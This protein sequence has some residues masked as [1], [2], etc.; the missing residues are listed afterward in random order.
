MKKNGFSKKKLAVFTLIFALIGGL[1]I[2]NSL[3]APN[4]NLLGD[5]DGDNT[6]NIQDLSILLSNYGTTNSTADINSDGT[7]NVLDLSTLLSHYGESYSGGQGNYCPNLSLGQCVPYDAASLWNTP[8]PADVTTDPMSATFI[9]AISDNNLSLTSDPDQYTI[10]VYLVDNNTPTYTVTGSGYFHSYDAGNDTSSVGH[11]SPWAISGVPI[12]NGAAAGVGTD[13]QIILWNP[14]TGVKYEFWQFIQNSGGSYSA[15][16]GNREHTTNGYYGRFGDGLAGRGA[17][18][19]Y[20]AGLVRKWEV[21]QGQI[22][23]ALAFA[24]N[25]PSSNYRYPASKSDG[26]NFGG[27]LNVD[28]PEG[29]RLQLDPTLSDSY[30]QNIGLSPPAIVIAHALQKY[31]MIVVDH[32]GSSKIYLE[33]RTTAGWNSSITRNMLSTIPWSKFRV[34][35]T[36]TGPQ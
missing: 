32:S 1:I 16:N 10:P 27:V 8:I 21:D 24:Y 2:W 17:G 34:I 6:V 4:P 11:G 23:H 7:V 26:G 36:Q 29:A 35:S 33:Q 25:S 30:F 28:L 15:T 3:A 12:P 31:G 18:T 5:L 14:V 22:N 19:P 20:F 9:N 13:G